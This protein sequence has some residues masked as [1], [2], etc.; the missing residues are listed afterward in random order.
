M[1]NLE[2]KGECKVS[3]KDLKPG[4]TVV[5]HPVGTAGTTSEGVI[6]EIITEPE[7]VGDTQKKVQASE[8]Q[9]RILIKNSNTGKET[10]YK[11]ENI[12]SIKA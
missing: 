1:S 9:P 3:L 8:E 11:L 4:Q 10:A 7:V 2:T 5:Y 12:E 6:Q